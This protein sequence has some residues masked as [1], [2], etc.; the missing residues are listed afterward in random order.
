MGFKYEKIKSAQIKKVQIGEKDYPELLNYIGNPPE[1]LYYIGDITMASR[2]SIA[3]VGARKAT[4]YGKWAAYGFAKKLSEY[5]ICVVS[6][7]AY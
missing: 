2:P 7:M 5:G 1:M 6:G 4:A 3:I